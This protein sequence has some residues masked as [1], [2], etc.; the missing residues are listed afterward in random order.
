MPGTGA[1]KTEQRDS[2]G[3]SLSGL[4]RG[5]SSTAASGQPDSLPGG[6]GL[7]TCVFQEKA[8]WELITFSGLGSRVT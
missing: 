8:D 7:Q 3:L 5:L 2:L 1:K 4:P 6:S